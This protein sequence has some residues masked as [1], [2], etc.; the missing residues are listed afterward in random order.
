MEGATQT[1]GK[2]LQAQGT[3][4]LRPQQGVSGELEAN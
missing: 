2:S 4:R 1:C 3:V